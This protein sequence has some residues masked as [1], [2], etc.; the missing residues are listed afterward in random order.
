MMKMY[1]KMVHLSFI[2]SMNKITVK[3]I[4]N[5]GKFRLLVDEMKIIFPIEIKAN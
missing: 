1:I 4:V 5:R 2:Y 3:M